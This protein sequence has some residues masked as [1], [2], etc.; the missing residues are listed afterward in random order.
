[1]GELRNQVH[2]LITLPND[3]LLQ[4]L[5]KIQV[6]SPLR[7][8]SVDWQNNS[9]YAMLLKTG[10]INQDFSALRAI[11]KNLGGRALFATG[12]GSGEDFVKNVEEYLSRY[13]IWEIALLIWIVF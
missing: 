10:L 8:R 3:V 6:F 5:K 2:G 11:F 7:S 12:S 9:I 13:Y 4:E 1:M